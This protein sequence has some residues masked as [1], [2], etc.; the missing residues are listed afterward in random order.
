MAFVKAQKTRSYFKRFQVKFKRRRQGKIDYCA[1]VRLLNQDKDKYNTPK[2]RYV[3]RFSNKDITAQIISATIVGD[4]VLASAYAHELPHYGLKVGLTNYVAAYCTGLLLARR[5]GED[6]SVEPGESRRPFRALLD[7][8]LIQTTTGNR[9]FGALKGAL[10]GGLDIPH[11]EKRFAGFDKDG[12]S[13]DADVHRKYI[14]GGHVAT[15]MNT[16]MED[17]PEKYQTHFSDYIKAGV[18]PDNLEEIYKKVHAAIRAD[19]S[20]KKSEK[21]QP[22]EHKRYNLK[23]LT[24]DERKLRSPHFSHKSQAE[25]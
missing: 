22:K 14:Y 4:I 17:E 10:D 25:I 12:K 20:P 11:S 13:L 24:Y 23:M 9:V 6:Y 5:V 8:G 15:Y 21:Q 18:E 7:V 19:P 2:Y 3:V 1:R 16:L